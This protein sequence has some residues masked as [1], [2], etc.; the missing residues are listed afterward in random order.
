MN[1][2]SS[3]KVKSIKLLVRIRALCTKKIVVF[4]CTKYGFFTVLQ[5][6]EFQLVCF[7]LTFSGSKNF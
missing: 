4:A 3:T 5:V 6:S 7:A 1:S 2:H